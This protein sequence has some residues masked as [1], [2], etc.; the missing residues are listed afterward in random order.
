MKKEYV[1]ALMELVN[2]KEE[3]VVRLKEQLDNLAD[4]YFRV[5]IL[6]TLAPLKMR[7]ELGNLLSFAEYEATLKCRLGY[8]LDKIAHQRDEI[9]TVIADNVN[10]IL[11]LRDEISNAYDE[12]E[13][14]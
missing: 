13:V 4:E 7:D 12:R 8:K 9:E 10:A 3:M 1:N 6:Y 14:K 11:T 5:S 2:E